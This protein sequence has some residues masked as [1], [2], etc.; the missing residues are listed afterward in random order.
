MRESPIDEKV[1]KDMMALYYKKQEEQKKLESEPDENYS[2][3]VWANPGALKGSLVNGGRDIH[4]K[5]K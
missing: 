5:F 3:S 4:F 1:Q 2:Q